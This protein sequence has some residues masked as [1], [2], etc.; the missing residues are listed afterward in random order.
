[1]LPVALRVVVGWLGVLGLVACGLALDVAGGFP[2]YLALWP[3][4]CAAAV[5]VAG[6]TGHPLGVDR[7]LAS[8]PARYVGDLS[9]ALYL[10]H[11]PVLVLAL[12]AEHGTVPGPR[13][14]LLVI[15]TAVLLAVATR[16]LVEVPLRRARDRGTGAWPDHRVAVVAVVAVA[17]L[18]AGW[19]V[20]LTGRAGQDVAL[21]DPDHPG[22]AVRLAGADPAVPDA[23][24]LP[25]QVALSTDWSQPIGPCRPGRTDPALEV[26]ERAAPGGAARH[27]VVV[28]DS[29]AQQLVPAVLPT[30]DARGWDLTTMLKG[31]C[32]FALGPGVDPE[33]Q[34]WNLAAVDEITAERPDVVVVQASHLQAGGV[35]TTPPG[36]ATAWQ[37]LAERD[38]P[39]LA[40]RDNPRF[41][42]APSWCVFGEYAPDV[43][44]STPR[45]DAV[46]SVPSYAVVSGVPSNVSFLDLSDL[47]CL[48]DVCP[49]AIGNVLVYLDDNHVSASFARTMAPAV[50]TELD[51]LPG[52]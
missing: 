41:G 17:V 8:R 23:A 16:H 21:A 7:V 50:A 11:W 44:C 32:P 9:F 48:P 24:L 39:V 6:R 12:V 2:G 33:C 30:T 14:G 42:I 1:V 10:W 18:V 47:Y 15:A 38:I 25:S 35:E 26:C 52:W 34:R 43:P 4:A 45:P 37:A 31:A 13:T 36:F 27:V 29:H 3:V 46:P 51:R 22:A 49:P 28:G 5:I 19:Q 40:V 20:A